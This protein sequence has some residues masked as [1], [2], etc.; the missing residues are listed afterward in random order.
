MHLSKGV[1]RAAHVAAHRRVLAG[2]LLEVEVEVS[3]SLPGMVVVGLPDAA[4]R[5]SQDRERANYALFNSSSVSVTSGAR[6]EAA[7]PEVARAAA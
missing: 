6:K 4:V 3:Q 7:E 5:E 2:A 1:F